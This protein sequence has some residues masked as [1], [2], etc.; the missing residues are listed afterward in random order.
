MNQDFKIMNLFSRISDFLLLNFLFII[1]SLP[2]ITLGA[3][4]TA[5]Y[6]VNL[7]MVKNEESYVARDFFRSFRQNFKI[8]TPAFLLFLLAGTLM[9]ANIFISFQANETFYLFLRA[10][11]TIF[12]ISIIVC[13]KYF[14]PILARFQFSFKQ[15]WM[16]IPHMI[17]TQ[18]GYFLFLVLLNIP[19]I[20]LIM[21]SVYTSFFVLIIGCIFGFAIFTYAEAFLFRKIFKGYERDCTTAHASRTSSI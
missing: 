12:L 15:I 13:A 16:H 10:L 19:V 9:G 18:A 11:A 14:F 21:Y 17:I 20:F 4:V 1:T 2:V 6:S 8:A 3:S 7:K 5:L